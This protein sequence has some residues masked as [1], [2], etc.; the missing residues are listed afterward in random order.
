[1][2]QPTE[3]D[4]RRFGERMPTSD[5]AKTHNSDDWSSRCNKENWP[6][7]SGGE[8][9]NGKEKYPT[10]NH[11]RDRKNKDDVDK[12]SSSRSDKH[13]TNDRNTQKNLSTKVKPEK[14]IGKA[15]S[16]SPAKRSR[17][18]DQLIT[19]RHSDGFRKAS[20][21]SSRKGDEDNKNN[22]RRS[23]QEEI[24]PK[25]MKIEY[26]RSSNSGLKAAV[27]SSQP[28]E[29]PACK[30]ELYEAISRESTPYS[31]S[32]CLPGEGEEAENEF[33]Q[34]FICPL[35]SLTMRT[36]YRM[37]IVC[38]S[39]AHL[40]RT[41]CAQICISRI[42]LLAGFGCGRMVSADYTAFTR[43]SVAFR[44]RRPSSWG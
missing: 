43:G 1:M 5:R 17:T 20:G 9:V 18:L 36:A 29:L 23:R 44:G 11:A 39:Y 19:S 26:S 12:T 22:D 30:S 31:P 6:G 25:M 14:D 41:D 21:P 15:R 8:Q 42:F 40:M 3:P 4:I 27:S 16:F 10:Y 38:V 35:E 13:S 33:C 2:L 32:G 37:R 24:G 7:E 28:S 34:V